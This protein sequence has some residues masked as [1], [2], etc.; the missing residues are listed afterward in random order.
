M[1]R[2]DQAARLLITVQQTRRA[3]SA[4]GRKIGSSTPEGLGVSRETSR[5]YCG[6]V[7]GKSTHSPMT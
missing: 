5:P 6:A 3:S 2:F 1:R 4:T 7:A